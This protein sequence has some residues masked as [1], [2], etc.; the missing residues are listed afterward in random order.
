MFNPDALSPTQKR[1]VIEIGD[2]RVEYGTGTRHPIERWVF[3]ASTKGLRE[4]TLKALIKKGAVYFD[5]NHP[6]FNMTDYYRLTDEALA[7]AKEQT[8]EQG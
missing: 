8:N 2:N 3:C 4:S 1:A 6:F 7:W 5:G